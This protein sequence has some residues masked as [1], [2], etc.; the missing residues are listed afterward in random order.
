MA[1]VYL[2]DDLRHERKV[3]IKLL[4]PELAAVIGAERFVVEIKTTANLQHPHILPLFDSGTADGFLYYVMP[5]I[6]GE[7]LRSKLDRENQLGV[8]EA[9]RI[10]VAVADALDYAHR[11]GVIHRDIKPENILLHDGRPVVADFGIALALS[12]AAG[13]RITETGMSLGTPHYMSPEQATADR[14]IT[15]RSDIYSLG[16]V[17]YEMLTGEPPHMGTSAQQIIMKIVT[18]DAQPVTRLRKSVPPNVA[19]A[20]AKAVERLPADRFETAGAFAHALT[21][22]AFRHG[23]APAA[24]VTAGPHARARRVTAAAPWL[25]AALAVAAAVAAFAWPRPPEPVR[26]YGLALPPDQSV[27][28]HRAVPSPDGSSIV[29]VGPV[30]GQ[31]TETVYQLWI[32]YRDRYEAAPIPGTVG[33]WNVTFSPDGRWLA[34]VRQGRLMKTALSGG[35]GVALADS[36]ALNDS[37]IAWLDDGNIVFIGRQ[38]RGLWRVSSAGGTKELVFAADAPIFEPSPLPGSKAVLVGQCADASCAATRLLA[39]NL[40]AGTAKT[41]MDGAQSGSYLPTGHLLYVRDDLSVFAAEFDAAKL[42]TRGS[43]VSIIDSVAFTYFSPQ[44]AVSKAGTMVIRRGSGIGAASG[45]YE[46]VW[47]DRSGSTTPVDMGGTL[48]IDPGGGN[49]GWALSPDGRRLAIGLLTASGG[50]IWVKQ[51]PNGPLSRVSFDSLPDIRPRWL[52][53]GRNL[54]FVANRP[55]GSELHRISADGTGDETVLARH[56]DAIFEG[57][58]SP[59]GEWTVVR[60][61]GGLGR[62]GRDI[63]GFRRGDTVPVALVASPS[64]DENAFGLS[65]DGRWIAYESD[66]TG[67][68]EVYVRPFPETGAGKWQASTAGGYAPLWAPNGRELFFVDAERRMTAMSFAPGDPPQLGERRVLFALTPDIYLWEND[69]YTPFDISPD[70]RRFIMARRVQVGAVEERPVVVV[71]NWFTELRERLRGE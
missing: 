38:G 63:V 32:K 19:A 29:F 56:P 6:A 66:E 54:A 43:P 44:I 10:A 34:Y 37:G 59:D 70:G 39:V 49:P 24:S 30:T 46:M 36:V 18:E 2:A 3:A 35:S 23:A 52:P 62:Q 69:Y 47:L 50:D 53:D 5:Y 21:D 7:T 55:G 20:V 40:D 8:D 67:R 57:T 25:I 65:P 9:V 60:I 51:L 4:K 28:A 41:V 11:Q 22:P 45:R 31:P 33:V 14:E 17:L 48:T 71:E 61:R 12:A 68:R 16:S 42:E 26:R 13:G 64:F 1:T 58:V 15:G 27:L